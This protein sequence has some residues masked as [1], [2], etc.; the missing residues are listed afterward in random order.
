MHFFVPRPRGVP[1]FGDVVTA[2]SFRATQS[3]LRIVH[4]LVDGVE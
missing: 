1:L 3:N 2:K 4:P